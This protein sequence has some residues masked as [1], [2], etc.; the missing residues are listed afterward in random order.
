MA[1]P[2]D[3]DKIPTQSPERNPDLDREQTINP[4]SENVQGRAEDEDEDEFEEVEEEEDE[5]EEEGEIGEA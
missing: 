1:Q 2:R 3:S 4:E 5:E